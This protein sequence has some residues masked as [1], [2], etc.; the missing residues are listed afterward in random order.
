[1]D[2]RDPCGAWEGG[3]VKVRV[4]VA[5][6]WAID[7]AGHVWPF[8]LFGL[9]LFL[10]WG[11]LRQIHPRD[12]R[13]AF[14]ALDQRWLAVALALTAANVAVMGLYD[15]VAFRHTRTSWTQRWKFGAVAFAWT[16]FL[17]LGPLAGP[18][19]RFWLYKPA[20]E[21]NSELHSGVLSVTLAFLSGLT[22]WTMATLI[23]ARTGAG[24][25]TLV[26]LSLPFVLWAT[27]VATWCARRIKRLAGPMA[28]AP[29]VIELA[30]VGWLD[31]ALA[32]AVFVACT[33]AV[34]VDPA[35][36]PRSI[37]SFFFGQI[38]GLASL[39]PGGFGSSDAFWIAHLPLNTSVAAAA[40][41]AYRAI[42]YIAPWVI[43]S[44]LLLSWV[45]HRAPRRLEIARRVV[46]SL[47]G[48]GGLLIILSSASPAVHARLPLLRRLVPLPLVE[49]SVVTAALTGLVLLVL[50][51]G[52]A[53]GYRSAFRATMMLLTLGG[54][55][56][57]L[58]GLD[59][60]EALILLAVAAAARSQAPLFDRESRGRTLDVSDLVLALTGLA[61]FIVCG[62]FSFHLR[63]TS[64]EH[65]S[66]IG[67][68]LQTARFIRAAGSMTLIVA[69]GA[70]YLLMRTPVR[71]TRLADDEIEQ[72]LRTH[73]DIGHATNAMMVGTG[74]K[75]VFSLDG[76]RGFCLY[77]TIG[78]YMAIFADPVVSSPHERAAMLDAVFAHAG[79]LDRRPVFYQISPDWMPS[80][81]DRGSAFFKMGEDAHVNLDR[82][83]LDGS[84]GKLNRQF[85]RRAERDG[86]SFRIMDTDEVARRM[87]DLRQVSDEWLETKRVSERQFSVGFFDEAY[88]R[89]CRCA[90]VEDGGGR[91]LAFANLLEGPRQTELSV[92]LMRYRTGGPSVMDF[93]MV[94]LLL[95]GKRL[96]YAVFYRLLRAISDLDIPLDSGDFCLMDRQVVAALKQLPERQR[97]V[98]GLRTFVG[99]R[100]VGLTYER[101]ARNAG[102]PKYTFKALVRLAVDG[103]VSFS[104]YPLALVTYM[105]VFS[106][107]VALVLT[108][109]VFVDAWSNTSSPRGWA[110]TMIVVMYMGGV[111]LVSL[112]IMAE[113]I[114]RIFL[115]VKGRPTYVLGR[116]V[117]RGQ[118][119]GWQES[120]AA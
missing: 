46:A 119:Q 60:E 55:A 74:D 38:L 68:G 10:S 78:P 5:M 118:E 114:R 2:R 25:V 45:T 106:L 3:Q 87:S 75:S 50:A 12:V 101:D 109:W 81:H 26:S 8:L 94:S 104:G 113:Y 65:W 97:F 67:Y 115:E 103:L 98:R 35:L 56:A 72:T 110:S 24:I 20:V 27:T 83:A 117:R 69:A 37:E 70:I 58:K 41:M 79:G 29:R 88:L 54:I 99:F 6:A 63:V 4:E 31:W 90:V 93:M 57:M 44:L 16:N 42:Y 30:S 7:R 21:E 23:T 17:T 13:H 85:L 77:R 36:L 51:R 52:L 47:V 66:S 73:S 34:G 96:G 116:I 28:A 120:R 71:F 40:L 86:V 82:V 22:G 64:L 105:G 61:L 11:P 100:Q 49:A 112:G 108:G 111:Q 84:A 95:E 59:W 1:M 76:G 92:D 15:V 48:A 39:V 33:R 107:C 18:A 43:A 53:R 32:A 62:T 89:R 80:L 102:E 9:V 19:V 91:I 14:Q